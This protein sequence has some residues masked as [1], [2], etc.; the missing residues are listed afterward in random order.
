M[1]RSRC[2]WCRSL[3]VIA[4]R[5][6]VVVVLRRVLCE[7]SAGTLA[8]RCGTMCA[9][10]RAPAQRTKTL[11]NLGENRGLRMWGVIPIHPPVQTC[12]KFAFAMA[13]H[14][15]C[16]FPRSLT[17][18]TKKMGNLEKNAQSTIPGSASTCRAMD[19]F[20]GSANAPRRAQRSHQPTFSL[21]KKRAD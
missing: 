13:L 6:L 9:C 19:F 10:A 11:F 15:V 2:R 1:D 7:V 3:N 8:S 14:S 17:F 18:R 5:V 21:E 12:Y 4:V 20:M 16:V